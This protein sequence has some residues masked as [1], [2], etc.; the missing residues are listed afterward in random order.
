MITKNDIF[1][2]IFEA[3]K[4]SGVINTS[5]IQIDFHFKL[6]GHGSELDSMDFIALIVDIEQRISDKY[7]KSIS[8]TAEKAMSQTN[9]PFR[10]VDTLS[11]Y[12][13]TLL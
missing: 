3:I 13:L 7:D 10:T 11:D 6:V 2:I 1:E 9:S 12:I 5:E 8:I 4:E